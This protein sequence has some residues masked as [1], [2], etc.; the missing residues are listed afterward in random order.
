VNQLGKSL[1]SILG[2]GILALRAVHL[3][4]ASGRATGLAS[5]TVRAA[6]TEIRAAGKKEESHR[7][8]PV[9]LAAVIQRKVVVF[10]AS[11][12]PQKVV[13]NPMKSHPSGGGRASGT[14]GALADMQCA[15]AAMTAF[16]RCVAPERRPI[17]RRKCGKD[18]T[19][20]GGRVGATNSHKSNK[21]NAA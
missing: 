10:V 13:T 6:T 14:S 20:G 18:N 7:A 8:K 12:S 9:I 15:G 17:T 19:D 5:A 21:E 16:D 11:Q 3:V 4:N 1:S 2:E